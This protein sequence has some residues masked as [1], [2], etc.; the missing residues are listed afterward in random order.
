MYV[1]K[2]VLVVTENRQTEF[3]TV[4]L[5]NEVRIG[6]AMRVKRALQKANRSASVMA[7]AA[8]FPMR[9][10]TARFFAPGLDFAAL[11]LAFAGI[12]CKL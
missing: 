7:S 11:G 5:P 3:T 6:G 8:L 10:R 12:M 2:V 1:D 9:D 4:W